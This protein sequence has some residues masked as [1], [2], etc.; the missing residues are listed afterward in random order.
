MLTFCDTTKLPKLQPSLP[1]SLK[2]YV[3]ITLLGVNPLSLGIN[4]SSP[5][6]TL[7]ANLK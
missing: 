7:P 3:L 6:D 5:I 2:V 1:F 4:T